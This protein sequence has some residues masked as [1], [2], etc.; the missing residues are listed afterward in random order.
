MLLLLQVSPE[1]KDFLAELLE[2]DV[3][4]RLDVLSAMQHPWVTLGGGAPLASMQQQ[5]LAQSM[6]VP[7]IALEGVQVSQEDIDAA[8]RQIGSGTYEL[9]DVA[10]EEQHFSMG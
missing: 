1:L 4:K 10:F 2:K 9:M 8:I 7:S 6:D 5:R 3:L